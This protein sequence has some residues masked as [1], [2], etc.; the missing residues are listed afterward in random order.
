MPQGVRRRLRPGDTGFSFD[1]SHVLAGAF[2]VTSEG[3]FRGDLVSRGRIAAT[4]PFTLVYHIRPE[5]RWSD[6]VPV[7][8]QDFVFTYQVLRRYGQAAYESER[9]RSVRKIDRKT[10]RVVLR[11]PYVDWRYLFDIV[12]PKHALA[13]ENLMT[14][15][16]DG[17][18]NPKTGKAIGSGPF[19]VG[20]WQRG[21]QLSFVR[22][23]R[24]WGPHVAHLDRLV[25]RFLPPRRRR[26]RA[27]HGRDRPDLPQCCRARGSGPGAA[28]AARAWNQRRHCAQQRI[29]APLD[30]DR[31]GRASRAQGDGP[32]AGRS[33]TGSTAW[34]WPARSDD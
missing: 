19:L 30:P 34:Q 25:Y 27:A 10:V 9:I 4:E 12:L 33:P 14:V 16:R 32:S 24:Y 18:D 5:A 3:T 7:S 17:I 22:N 20:P 23:Q 6:G 26:G 31:R 21:K 29:R 1:M 2:E 11:E 13:G 28:S 8:A 15:W